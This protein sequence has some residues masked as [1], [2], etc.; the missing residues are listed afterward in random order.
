M[1]NRAAGGLCVASLALCLAVPLR[2][3][4]S[5]PAGIPGLAYQA[6]VVL[7]GSVKITA[8]SGFSVTLEIQPKRAVKGSL[9]GAGLSPSGPVTWQAWANPITGAGTGYGL[10]FLKRDLAT[11][12]WSVI[13]AT[14]GTRRFA[15]TFIPLPQGDLPAGRQ[16]AASDPMIDKIVD[17]LWVGAGSANNT[18]ASAAYE[19]IL[20]VIGP[21][22]PGV[23]SSFEHVDDL[24]AVHRATCPSVML[25][26]QWDVSTIARVEGFLGQYPYGSVPRGFVASLCQ[27]RDS[28]ALPGLTRLLD[29]GLGGAPV[30][31]CVGAALRNIH[32]SGALPLL[33][34]LLESPDR[35]LEYLGVTGFGLHANNFPP[36][37]GSGGSRRGGARTAATLANTPSVR[38]FNLDPNRYL[39][40][41]KAW[42]P[43]QPPTGIIISGGGATCH[44]LSPS[45]PC[46]LPLAASGATDA[47]GDP[48]YYQW[49]GCS[50]STKS[51]ASCKVNAIGSV[52][53]TVTVTDG[54]AGTALASATVTGVNAAPTLSGPGPV[55]MPS[56]T[57]KS[58]AY[59]ETDD[60]G[61]LSC[62][63]S[64]DQPE[65]GTQIFVSNVSCKPGWDVTFDVYS[66]LCHD[67]YG[68]LYVNLRDAW[69][70]RA[71]K[72]TT[73]KGW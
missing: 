69:G 48:L 8:Q 23:P 71:T 55:S 42:Y 14:V 68:V 27:V 29:G 11:G 38:A 15:A 56:G 1:T 19:A 6:D 30:Q 49:S 72:K 4:V 65:Q 47:N 64:V 7:V 28:A 61:P 37:S 36:G 50:S 60:G 41:W 24:G 2:A 40:F 59:N 66:E 22:S 26:A 25:A 17:E 34:R 16:Y 46:V 43:N 51:Q 20:S 13:P 63:V 3:A 44:P 21:A 70:V 73:L 12:A 9:D 5:V 67:C 58:L 62:W 39:S 31:G 57:A 54:R 33:A 52:T 18:I 32:T 35:S 45:S 53:G 10:W